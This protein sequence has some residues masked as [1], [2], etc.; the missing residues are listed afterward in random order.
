MSIPSWRSVTLW[1]LVLLCDPMVA[2]QALSQDEETGVATVPKL[3]SEL[4]KALEQY[5]KELNSNKISERDEAENRIV[6]LGPSVIDLLPP[7]SDADSEDLRLRVERIRKTLEKEDQ[8]V[9][10]SPSSVDLSGVMTGR[11]ALLKIATMTGNIIRLEGVP[12]LDKQVTTAF[13]DTPFWEAF[14]EVLDQLGLT[15]ASGDGEDIQLIP[16]AE[17]TPLRIETAG[18]SGVFRFE[19]VMVTKIS[20]LQNPQS[21]SMMIDLLFSWEPRLSPSLVRFQVE[22]MNIVCDNGEVL[23][24]KD[25]AEL[26][27]APIG[28]AQ[29]RVGVEVDMPSRQAK[30]IVKWSGLVYA[31]QPGKLASVAFTDLVKSKQKTLSNGMLSVTLEQARK[32]RGVFEV[33]IGVS[34]KASRD[35]NESVQAWSTLQDVYMFDKDLKRVDNVGWST[36]R[37]NENDIGMSYLFELEN[38]LEGCKFVYRA[39][40]S[41]NEQEIDFELTDIPLP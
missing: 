29:M 28:G 27:F 4:T 8:V 21:S 17:N 13:E 12:N 24:P 26:E 33:L 35:S 7:V 34:L 40:G 23:K 31:T 5:V 25:N 3:S 39:P 11:D 14:D 18:Y 1:I 16:Q 38:G 6:K 22:S 9:L 2:L 15:V 19:P 10:T 37:M 41:L 32:N 20:D 36:T 30:R